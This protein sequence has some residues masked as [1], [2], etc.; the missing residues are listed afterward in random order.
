MFPREIQFLIIEIVKILFDKY[1]RESRRSFV[2]SPF[3][4]VLTI[5]CSSSCLC[6]LFASTDEEN[7][8]AYKESGIS[9]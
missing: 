8:E 7:G 2:L 1:I 6:G 9:M 5:N 4:H 3:D